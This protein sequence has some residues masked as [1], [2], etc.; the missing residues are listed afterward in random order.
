MNDALVPVA[1]PPPPA[2]TLGRARRAERPLGRARRRRGGVELGCPGRRQARHPPLPDDIVWLPTAVEG[3]PDDP[4]RLR[5]ATPSPR[6]SR[7]A[8][9]CGRGAQ[10]RRPARARRRRRRRVRVAASAAQRVGPQ[11]RAPRVRHDPHG[12]ARRSR[13]A[14]GMGRPLRRDA[15]TRDAAAAAADASGGADEEAAPTPRRVRRERLRGG[16]VRRWLRAGGES[17]TASASCGARARTA[18]SASAT[19][20]ATTRSRSVSTRCRRRAARSRGGL[21]RGEQPRQLALA[22]PDSAQAFSVQF[23]NYFLA[24]SQ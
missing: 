11:R 3:V 10:P 14:V 21:G 4:C 15:A 23:R 24:S 9:S 22:T 5:A 1:L 2:P 7:R 17:S 16:G 20:A 8:A 18:A 13:R 6:C 19:T 12:G